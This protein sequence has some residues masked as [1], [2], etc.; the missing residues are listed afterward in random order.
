M[1]ENP[2]KGKLIVFEGGDGS[3][4]TEQVKFLENRLVNLGGKVHVWDFPQYAGGSFG[5]RVA[6]RMLAGK[7]GPLME[8]PTYLAAL[9]FV[10]DR[11]SVRDEMIQFMREGGVAIGN[12][13]TDSNLGHGGAKCATMAEARL[14]IDEFEQFEYGE[15]GLPMPDISFFLATDAELSRSLCLKK[16]GREYLGGAVI[17]DEAEKNLE[18]QTKTRAMY[19]YLCATRRR[20]ARIECMIGPGEIDSREEIHGRVWEELNRRFVV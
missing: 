1:T 19:E 7:F 17:T 4:K 20:F 12:R 2:K 8:I 3:G 15:M 6:G 16:A 14:F 9:P 5:A 13:F 18:H 10:F 11:L